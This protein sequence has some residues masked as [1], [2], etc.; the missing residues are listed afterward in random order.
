MSKMD[1][2]GHA[3]LR[4]TSPVSKPL[5]NPFE[6]QLRNFPQVFSIQWSEDD[7]LINPWTISGHWGTHDQQEWQA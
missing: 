1:Q 5:L 4:L 6:L 2:I 3:D 7:V